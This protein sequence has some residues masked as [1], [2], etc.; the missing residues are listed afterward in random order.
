MANM[1]KT[2]NSE[3]ATNAATAANA[4]N[5]VT[6]ANIANPAI[7]FNT[8]GFNIVPPHTE[9]NHILTRSDKLGALK[10]RL[11]FGRNTY[12]VTPG[13]YSI[14]KPDASAPVLVT[15]NYKLTFDTVRKTLEGFSAWILVLDT[16]GV[17]VWCAA[18]KGTFGTSELVNRI[19]S[20]NLSAVVNHKRI[21]LPQLGAPGVS[22]HEVTSKTG[23]KVVYGPVR[24]EDI[25]AFVAAGYEATVEMRTVTFTFKDRAVLTPVEL[26]PA[27]KKSLLI[28]GVLFILNGLGVGRFTGMDIWAVLGTVF[29]GAVMVPLL[30][31]YIPGRAFSFKGWL[32]GILWT[33]FVIW[34]NDLINLPSIPW[35]RMAAYVT[36]LP[37]I[38]AYIG[39]NFTGASTYTSFSG[40][41]KEMK[42][43]LPIMLVSVGVGLVFLLIE[44]ISEVLI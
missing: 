3:N 10:V 31:T 44:M 19:Q 20:V 8:L 30:L 33:I 35:L 7:S 42:I 25:K 23:F 22:A 6:A 5:T 1:D 28:F 18:G 9:T 13:L 43:A 17:N 2:V 21:I 11:G 34:R 14:G 37:M 32:L 38:S 39:M 24:A 26:L 15:S 27:L 40:V 29:A 41:K 16:K 36:I 12:T 4:A